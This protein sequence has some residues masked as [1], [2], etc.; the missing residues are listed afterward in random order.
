MC[1]CRFTHSNV[2]IVSYCMCFLPGDTS[3]NIK[4]G[5]FC[6]HTTNDEPLQSTGDVM[7]VQFIS[8]ATIN[9]TGFS[10]EFKKGV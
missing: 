3:A 2:L 9:R 1:L 10:A 5:K 6:G 7:T 8:D 4:L